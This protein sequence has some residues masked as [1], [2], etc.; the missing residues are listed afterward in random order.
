M[1]LLA[2][3][4]YI[5]L[6]RTKLRDNY[7]R[8]RH[9]HKNYLPS[10]CTRARQKEI[11]PCQ[12]SYKFY[13]HYEPDT[14]SFPVLVPLDLEYIQVFYNVM[15][16]TGPYNI[17]KTTLFISATKRTEM[18]Q[19]FPHWASWSQTFDLGQTVALL[20]TPNSGVLLVIVTVIPRMG[21]AQDTWTSQSSSDPGFTKM[22]MQVHIMRHVGP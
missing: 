19:F 6:Y 13:V 8:H 4:Y 15:N 10:N 11:A 22:S 1:H 3:N 16:S 12:E 9:L 14:S 20:S 18:F 2:T 5:I 17:F 21:L 7:F